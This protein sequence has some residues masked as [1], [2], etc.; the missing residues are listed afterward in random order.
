MFSTLTD[1]GAAVTVEALASGA[2]DY[3]LKPSGVGRAAEALDRV[4]LDVLPKVKAVCAPAP[5]AL[6]A[7][8]SLSRRPSLSS[9]P[10]ERVEVLAI[11]TSTGGP[12]ALTSLLSGM[13]G[14]LAVPVVIVQH[15]P[16][17]FTKLLADRLDRVSSLSV[18]E[19]AEPMP[20]ER[21]HV[22]VAPGGRHLVVES[23]YGTVW[24]VQAD[25]PP[26][27]SCRPAVDV[28]FGS[29]AEVYGPGRSASS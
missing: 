14:S 3:V 1:R 10:T 5:A 28:L 20:L 22:Y 2:V 18:K 8:P 16:P 12:N 9:K 17:Q 15:M 6:V 7:A 25:T 29:V 19:A 24:A 11:G 23:R 26:V 27:H 13:P 4:R 21:G